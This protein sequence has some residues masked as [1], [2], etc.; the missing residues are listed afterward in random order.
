MN[1][2]YRKR[3]FV[4]SNWCLALLT[5]VAGGCVEP[6]YD[7]RDMTS[8]PIRIAADYQTT[9]RVTDAGFAD[10]DRM[11]IF[12]T[13]YVNGTPQAIGV[14]GNRATNLLYTYH[15]SGNMWEG[16]ATVYWKDNQ[17]PVDVVGYYPYDNEL[18]A[19][20]EYAFA[21]QANQGSAATEAVPGGYEASDLLWAKS[22]Q[23]APTSETIR[24]MYKHLM[25]GVTVRLMEGGGFA[26]GEWAE[27]VK[28]VW[29]DNTVL[30]ATVNLEQGTVTVN[31][32]EPEPIVTLPYLNDYRAVVVP[33]EVAAGKIVIGITVD[34]VN[35]ELTKDA[36]LTY[37]S[38]KMHTFT[39]EV[40]KRAATGDYAFTLTNEAVTAWVDDPDF[41][42]GLVR[43]YITV[44]VDEPGQ[45]EQSLQAQGLDAKKISSL[46]VMGTVNWADLTFMGQ[47][48]PALTYLNLR[49]V[50][51]DDENDENDDVITLGYDRYA[52]AGRIYTLTRVILPS[53]LRGIG[54]YAFYATSLSGNLEIPEGVTFIGEAAFAEC[55]LHGEITLPSTLKRV[56]NQAFFRAEIE[57][58]LR[59]P[60][61]LEYIGNEAFECA[62]TYG[63][64]VGN[65]HGTLTLPSSLKYI[66]EAAF[67]RARF[68]GDLVIPQGVEMGGRVF[69]FCQFGHIEI[70]E[71]VETIGYEM[72]DEIPLTGELLLP[73][74]LKELKSACFRKTKISTVVLPEGLLQLEKGVFSGCSRLEGVITIP[75]GIVV[76]PEEL[77]NGC[78][79]LSGVHLHK[80]V[81]FIAKNAFLNC[82]NMNTLVCDA[83]TPPVVEEG[84]FDGVPKDNFSIEVPAEAV[85][86]YKMAEGWKE[87]KRITAYS[88]FV[89]RPATACAINTTHTETLI[90]NAQGPWTVSH[91]PDWCELSQTSG[92]G[93]TSIRL[94]INALAQGAADRKDSVVFALDGTQFTTYCAVEQKDYEYG[95]NELVTLQ[96]HTKGNGIDIL[97]LGDGYD[98]EALASGAYMDLVREEMEYFFALPPY[99]RFRDYFNV[100]A[101]IALSQETGINT[102]NTYRNTCFNTIYAGSEL[103]GGSGPQLMPDD[104]LI[105]PYITQTLKDTPFTEDKLRRTLV[106]LVPNTTEYDGVTYVY[107]DNRA[108][109]ICPRSE[110]AYPSDT[111]GVV[112]REAGGFGFGKLANESIRYNM[113]LPSSVASI[114]R[115]GQGRG[116]YQNVSLSGKMAEVP[117][118]HFIFDPRYSDDV[119]I[120]EGAFDYTRNV[121]RSEASS[122]M[123]IGIPYYNAISRQAITQRIKEYA[124][125]PF[126][127]EEFYAN[128]TNTWGSTTTR[129]AT[130]I[131]DGQ[132]QFSAPVFVRG[133]YIPNKP[134]R[135]KNVD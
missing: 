118:A 125:E 117:W 52:D 55:P 131:P 17:T 95:E 128:D 116:W 2:A 78:T 75:E 96:E 18:A 68:T 127:M 114:I 3:Y 107:E 90:L 110:Q 4:L 53:S 56:E 14:T 41:H 20:T 69:A 30:A 94:T 122:C 119:D 91:L 25:A 98:A 24:L 15:E 89:C 88:D 115:E 106:I 101:G 73:S 113:Y 50:R 83:V 59:L 64:Y 74:T 33:Q 19:V 6:E 121:F 8:T 126:D 62:S 67:S 35:Y 100:Y 87:F 21:V 13:D 93:R 44:A 82:Y 134:K 36:A 72:F 97:F 84:A 32:G 133:K 60:E 92:T 77:F 23:V 43:E 123:S 103:C 27:T 58:E 71:G 108:I 51:I 129:T 9:T 105:F 104:E 112:Q 63:G 80:D 34:G 54:E 16:A 81:V 1:T 38:G 135:K 61:G 46:K 85:A 42:D 111:R 26:E 37:T 124:G 5:F 86:A 65:L 99:D 39:I 130:V 48:M 79:M 7:D 11:G 31:E 120:F 40:D 102:V 76:I 12:I 22:Q 10:E 57:G 29:V 66:G 70:P 109:A 45:F 132:V 28:H 47:S 49:E